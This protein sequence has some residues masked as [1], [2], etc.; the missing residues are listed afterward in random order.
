MLTLKQAQ[1]LRPG[2]ILI[3]YNE[4]RWKVTSCKLWTNAHRVRVD[5]KHGLYTYDTLTEVN[6]PNGMCPLF[7]K[8]MIVTES[9]L[10][11][12]GDCF[13]ELPNGV[14][15]ILAQSTDTF[16]SEMAKNE[17]LCREITGGQ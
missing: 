17:L 6:F 9:E 11:T 7:T 3:G 15:R 14:L 12:L 16:I 8:E 1:K 13:E 2:D 5:L 4:K 10:T